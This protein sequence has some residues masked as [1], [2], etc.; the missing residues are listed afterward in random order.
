MFPSGTAEPWDSLS[1]AESGVGAGAH[2]R[3]VGGLSRIQRSLQMG[4]CWPTELSN[5]FVLLKLNVLCVVRLTHEAHYDIYQQ[6]QRSLMI[7]NDTVRQ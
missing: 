6:L 1:R 7:I 5:A 2:F 3:V 4:L